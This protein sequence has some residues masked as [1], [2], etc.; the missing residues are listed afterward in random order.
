[1]SKIIPTK[2]PRSTSTFIVPIR[3]QTTNLPCNYVLTSNVL[4]KFYKGNAIDAWSVDSNIAQFKKVGSF[5]QLLDMIRNCN[6]LYTT[7]L[8][9]YESKTF[10][11]SGKTQPPKCNRLVAVNY[12]IKQLCEMA[13]NYKDTTTKTNIPSYKSVKWMNLTYSE[14]LEIYVK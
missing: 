10:V 11:V 5:T 13:A 14:Y 1:M 2:A 12:P 3:K 4:I 7:V 6:I 8:F 9:S